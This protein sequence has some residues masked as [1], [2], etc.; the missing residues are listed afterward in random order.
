MLSTQEPSSGAGSSG[1]SGAYRSTRPNGRAAATAAPEPTATEQRTDSESAPGTAP[2]DWRCWL[3]RTT[4]PWSG[5]FAPMPSGCSTVTPTAGQAP[6]PRLPFQAAKLP[7]PRVSQPSTGQVGRCAERTDREPIEPSCA[8][9]HS[10]GVVCGS[11]SSQ[12]RPAT[13]AS[14]TKSA[15]RR[16]PPGRPRGEGG[17]AEDHDQQRQQD[18]RDSAQHHRRPVDGASGAAGPAASGASSA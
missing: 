6:V 11:T 9:R 3:Y 14:T 16:G 12:R 4:P 7:A 18:R 8:I 13:P 5:R 2:Q 1:S 10:V 15:V 17:D